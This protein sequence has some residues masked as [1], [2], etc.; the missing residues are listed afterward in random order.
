MNPLLVESLASILRH[1]LTSAAAY[2]VARSIWTPEEAST[3]A[4]AGAMAIIGIAWS[5]YQKHGARLKLVTALALP[6]TTEA[7][8]EQKIAQGEQA[9]VSTPKTEKPYLEAKP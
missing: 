8:V 6:A 3:Y 1:A 2:L 9:A 7:A 4:A 5:L